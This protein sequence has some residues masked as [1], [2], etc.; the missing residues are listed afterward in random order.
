MF[1]N[2]GDTARIIGR[3]CSAARNGLRCGAFSK[4]L[5]GC[6]GVCGLVSGFRKGA[7]GSTIFE[8]SFPSKGFCTFTIEE[9]APLN[10]VET[11]E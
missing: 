7:N 11:E 6:M 1:F 3:H 9:L 8:V 4:N 5:N 10:N 2:K